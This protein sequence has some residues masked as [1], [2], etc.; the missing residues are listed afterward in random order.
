M[1]PFKKG[2]LPI[3]EDSDSDESFHCQGRPWQLVEQYEA[4]MK[5]S[6]PISNSIN[7]PDDEEYFLYSTGLARLNPPNHSRKPEPHPYNLGFNRASTVYSSDSECTR[8][9]RPLLPMKEFAPMCLPDSPKLKSTKPSKSKLKWNIRIPRPS[10]FSRMALSPT[11]EADF[12]QSLDLSTIQP[13]SLR[14]SPPSR[15]SRRQ[16]MVFNINDL[17]DELK[18][19]KS[20]PEAGGSGT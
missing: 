1:P 9:G 15:S 6:Q 16:G 5:T 3:E 10:G 7:L 12:A 11:S 13:P 18:D 2:K 19:I 14:S 4:D 8:I 17:P 20:T